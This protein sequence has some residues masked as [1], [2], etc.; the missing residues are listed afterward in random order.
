MSST[1]R[2]GV[3]IIG[4]GVM[5]RRMAE[6]MNAHP[7]FRALIAHDPGN[8]SAEGIEL[9]SPDAVISDPRV[10]CV[11]IA[12]PPASHLDYVRRAAAAGKAVFCEKPLAANI[13]EAEAI[14]RILNTSALP[15]GVNFPFSTAANV[16]QLATLIE[17]GALGRI[18]DARLTL[19]FARWPRGWQEDAAGWLA[20]P[21]Q[22]GFI[23]E[24]VSHFLFAAL[25]LFG[26]GR[27]ERA[28]IT[29]GPLGTETALTAELVFG[30]VPL[31]I[32]AAV[33]GDI[34]D[35]NRFEVAGTRDR[36]ALTDWYRLDHG[37]RTGERAAYLP[38][39]LDALARRIETGGGP[40]AT[41]AEA[42]AVVR[43]VETLRAA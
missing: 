29:R 2:I 42:A 30:T 3:G 40:L 14:V 43:L 27:I 6:A 25:R 36:A 23:R 19:R 16:H 18:E 4:M 31:T 24:V 8:V 10:G 28:A 33:A 32:D 17:T 15:A 12:S 26:P 5:G 34:D 39:Q 35:H 21:E 7:R 1:E 38:G 20:R 9:A 13:G 41:A 11:Y 37:G 22:G